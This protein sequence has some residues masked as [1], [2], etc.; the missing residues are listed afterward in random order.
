MRLTPECNPIEAGNSFLKT[1]FGIGG[2]AVLQEFSD[3]EEFYDFQLEGTNTNGSV[4]E[5]SE[6]KTKKNKKNSF[7]P[8]PRLHSTW[9]FI[10]ED[11]ELIIKERN[12]EDNSQIV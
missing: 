5:K 8:R 4:F 3:L 1:P 10:N 12:N 6:P 2:K 11:L 9:H 7:R